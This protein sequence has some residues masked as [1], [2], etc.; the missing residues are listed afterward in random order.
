MSEKV[1]FNTLSPRQA[2]ALANSIP[3]RFFR[4]LDLVTPKFA[5]ALMSD[6]KLL[7]LWVF[8]VTG[9][10]LR[11]DERRRDEK[12]VRIYYSTGVLERAAGDWLGM[13]L[14]SL[15]EADK[16]VVSDMPIGL[17]DYYDVKIISDDE[18]IH[19][20][21]SFFCTVMVRSIGEAFRFVEEGMNSCYFVNQSNPS[22]V[23][24]VQDLLCAISNLKNG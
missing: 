7:D 17:N 12:R 18:R 19:D 15:R 9:L 2:A 6:P 8:R 23:C 13:V 21:T 20:P 14:A 3:P 22:S 4:A 11:P 16:L 24:A 5:D 10:R 1:L